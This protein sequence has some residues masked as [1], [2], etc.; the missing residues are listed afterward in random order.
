MGLASVHQVSDK[1]MVI[2]INKQESE[3]FL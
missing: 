3:F 1:T 2:A